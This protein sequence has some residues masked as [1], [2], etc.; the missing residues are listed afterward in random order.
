MNKECREACGGQGLK[1]ENRIGRLRGE[2]DVQCTF[3][4]NNNVLMQQV[5]INYEI[6][7]RLKLRV[8]EFYP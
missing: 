5:Y 7:I 6:Q 1:T 8:S 4:G 3:E 2:F